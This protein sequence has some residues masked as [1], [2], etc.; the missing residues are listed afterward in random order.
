MFVFKSTYPSEDSKSSAGI[1]FF[2]GLGEIFCAIFLIIDNINDSFSLAGASLLLL[3]GVYFSTQIFLLNKN[4]S[5]TMMSKGVLIGDRL[6]SKDEINSVELRF[7]SN[8]IKQSLYAKSF[9]VYLKSGEIIKF[10]SFFD[11]YKDI[12]SNF[13]RYEVYVKKIKFHL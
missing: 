2:V 5:V 9:Y 1:L 13:S 6:I 8:I 10:E 12:R 7:W 11:D 4:A 3:L